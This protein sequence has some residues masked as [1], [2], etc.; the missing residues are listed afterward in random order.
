MEKEMLAIMPSSFI[1]LNESGGIVEKNKK[2]V[3]EF[4]SDK[5]FEDFLEFIN[6]RFVGSQYYQVMVSHWSEY[7][8][9]R[10]NFSDTYTGY[11]RNSVEQHYRFIFFPY[12][13]KQTA[14]HII[15]VS[16]ERIATGNYSGIKERFA[17]LR[18]VSNDGVL[19]TDHDIITEINSEVT[20]ILG[21]Q[22]VDLVGGRLYDIIGI[23]D[24]RQTEK[25]FMKG[26]SKGFEVTAI[27][28]KNESIPIFIRS[29]VLY[30]KG[31]QQRVTVINDL[32]DMRNIQKS[33]EE[34]GALFEGVMDSVDDVVFVTDFDNK[35][36]E[37]NKSFETIV[38]YE[39]EEI[40]GKSK[41]SRLK[42]KV[43]QSL[44]DIEKLRVSEGKLR[45]IVNLTYDKAGEN[46]IYDV[47]R[48]IYKNNLGVPIGVITVGRN[49]TEIMKDKE[50][51]LKAYEVKNEFLA[52]V[53]HEIRTPMNGIMGMNQLLEMTVLSDE[54][55]GYLELLKSSS[56]TLMG[57]LDAI[58]NISNI[59]SGR[60]TLEKQT[61][62][63]GDLLVQI[64]VAFEERMKQKTLEFNIENNC[65]IE[66]VIGD[67]DKI[68]QVISALLENALK[69]TE[70]GSVKF[71]IICGSDEG[72][73]V[74]IA[75]VVKD[76]GCG[77]LKEEFEVFKLPFAQRDS[78]STRQHG[79]MGTGLA[80]ANEYV[81]FMGG[82]LLLNSENESGA[83]IMFTVK[84]LK[85]NGMEAKQL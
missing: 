32:R 81:K 14:L 19:I 85:F 51:V 83:E 4:E 24:K 56:D 36:I 67:Y 68:V 40:L 72:D 16:K 55:K 37:C 46:Q 33:L 30:Y 42:F 61:F 39:K 49:I 43:D 73:A 10:K 63:I 54:Q 50:E 23:K 48:T 60:L 70:E 41:L 82:T 44:A 53:S 64:R 71:Q 13:L 6:E 31:K 45:S 34:G 74:K 22:S 35:I 1:L 29:K 26:Y 5:I 66:Y 78:S 69:F 2:F 65:S 7:S 84:L 80:I 9:L 38:G 17:A 75:F 47:L 25:L 57:V 52:N 58:I 8:R 76:A 59:K 62:A 27:S 3:D 77:I 20:S 28:V 18:E 12:G 79:G 21:Y 15:N 11:N